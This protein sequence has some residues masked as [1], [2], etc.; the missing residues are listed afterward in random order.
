MKLPAME[1]FKPRNAARVR[2]R[3]PDGKYKAIYLG[4]WGSAEAQQKYDEIIAD[5]VTA[6]RNPD[7]TTTSLP[8]LCHRTPEPCG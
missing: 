2:I 1:H 8:L 7:R 4:K 5:L 3:Q 6:N